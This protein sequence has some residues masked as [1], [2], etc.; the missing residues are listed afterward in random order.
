MTR[1]VDATCQRCGIS[2]A[3]LSRRAIER[4][5]ARISRRVRSGDAALA[6]EGLTMLRQQGSPALYARLLE[7]TKVKRSGRLVAGP[8]FSFA[9]DADEA[10]VGQCALLIVLAE[11]PPESLPEGFVLS[12]ITKL[13]LSALALTTIPEQIGA[14]I[15][16]K[17]LDLSFNLLCS[18]PECLCDL[19]ALEHLDLRGNPLSSVPEGLE[20]VVVPSSR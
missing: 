20:G 15:G 9:A 2:P 1:T 8:V 12:A 5:A 4:E 7:G 3:M 13:D 6:E 18:L 19:P 11:A 17:T 16:L 14:F 10:G